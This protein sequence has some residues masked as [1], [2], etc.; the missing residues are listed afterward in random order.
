M[1]ISAVS[2]SS[3]TDDATVGS[4]IACLQGGKQ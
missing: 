4:F 1:K 2:T 3:T